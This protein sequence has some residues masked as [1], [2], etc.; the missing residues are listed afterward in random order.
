MNKITNPNPSTDVDNQAI[1]IEE[2]VE[3][4]SEI[5]EYLDA[6]IE[7]RERARRGLVPERTF[8]DELIDVNCTPMGQDYDYEP[9]E[10]WDILFDVWQT[11][12]VLLSDAMSIYRR[13]VDEQF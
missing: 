13:D 7:A 11:V 2:N 9:E 8:W 4:L 1:P 6:V 10:T 12:G 3:V 5:I